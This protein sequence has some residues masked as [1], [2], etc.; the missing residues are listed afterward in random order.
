MLGDINATK[1]LGPGVDCPVAVF[2]GGVE[3]EGRR[4]RTSSEVERVEEVRLL[5]KALEHKVVL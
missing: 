5:E 3:G 4:R 1:G 2:A